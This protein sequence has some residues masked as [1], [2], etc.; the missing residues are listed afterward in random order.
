MC[1]N[2]RLFW[3]SFCLGADKAMKRVHRLVRCPRSPRA[4]GGAGAR[5]GLGAEAHH[6]VVHVGD[7]HEQL[8]HVEVQVEHADRDQH[9]S[10]HAEA[11][12]QRQVRSDHHGHDGR[13]DEQSDREQECRHIGGAARAVHL[14][15][16]VRRG[17]EE[18]PDAG[19]RDHREHDRSA[20]GIEHGS[21]FLGRVMS[22][23]LEL[24]KH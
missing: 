22:E 3:W 18:V 19:L 12:S 13:G 20:V 23:G 6:L 5:L 17:A 16:L 10:E 7:R 24:G 4:R 14:D 9:D 1:Q 11:A 21:Y 15:D 8:A 2:D